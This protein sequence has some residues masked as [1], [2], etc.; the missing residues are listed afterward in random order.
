LLFPALDAAHFERAEIYSLDGARAMVESGDWLVPRYR[1]EPFFDK[2]PLAYW[3]M[4]ASFRLFGVTPGAARVVPAAAALGVLLAT[5]WVGTLLFDRRAALAGGLVLATT[6]A[7]VNFGRIA[8]SDMLLALWTTLALGAG[9]VAFGDAPPRWALPALGAVLGLGF[10]TKGPIALLLPGL[11]LLLLA[12]RR[13][14][15]LP[16]APAASWAAAALLFAAA[17]LSWWLAVYLRMGSGPLAYFFLRE[18]VERFAGETYDVGRP[19]WF[20]LVTY[21]LEGLPWSVLLA[22]ALA[23]LLAPASPWRPG[24]RL[25]AAWIALVLVPL[26]LSR[27]KIDYYILPLYPAVSL[28]VGAYAAAAPWGRLE[29]TAARLALLVTS[30]LLA[31]LGVLASRLPAGWAAGPSDVALAFAWSAVCAVAALRAPARALLV[32]AGAAASAF[33]GATAR[34]LPAF[35]A[36]QPN[37]AIVEDVGRERIYRPDARV[38]LCQDPTRVQRDLLFHLRLAV[39]ET[40]E[41]WGA[42]S[43]P[44]P[45]LLLLTAEEWASL[46]RLRE[47]RKVAEY[48]YVPD[49]T[50]T[51]AG[52]LAPPPPGRLYLAAN[53]E[54][55]DPVFRERDR[56]ERKA[57]RRWWHQRH[58]ATALP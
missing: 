11:A 28:L 2:P 18:N 51:L 16:A 26:S 4:A 20:Y 47:L 13:R 41:L 34:A 27:G 45:H 23:R 46:S 3:L 15:L 38:A 57:F 30:A 53:F 43:A 21:L 5:V 36:G 14:R 17:G 25:L 40:C 19:P 56:L 1:D 10:L 7:F 55:E 35:L 32:L 50:L 54:T 42:V 31:G 58:A 8:M 48:G 37:R 29:R 33:S 39:L 22:P 49:T 12:A 24:A 6:A 9:L 52:L 44:A